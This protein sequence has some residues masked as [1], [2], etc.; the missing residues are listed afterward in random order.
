MK[1]IISF[2][3]VLMLFFITIDSVKAEDEG[4]CF[5]KNE[6]EITYSSADN[7]CTSDYDCSSYC[8]SIQKGSGRCV[9]TEDDYR[10]ITIRDNSNNEYK[11]KKKKQEPSIV[12][13]P[14]VSSCE[15][16]LGKNLSELIKL[17]IVIFQ[18]A[19]VIFSVVKGMLLLIP[20]IMAKK[21]NELAKSGKK[22]ATYALVLLAALL[23]KPLVVIIGKIANLDVSCITWII[24]TFIS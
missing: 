11:E 21:D 16:I 14:E 7:S 6:D 19:A 24:N 20:P 22:L 2:L 4:F 18:V 1:K 8:S 3:L 15:K 10:S 12:I 23:I 13:D 5:C 17:G 9:K